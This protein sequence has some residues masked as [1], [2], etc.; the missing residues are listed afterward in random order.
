VR[1]PDGLAVKIPTWMISP[2][3]AQHKLSEQAEL[4]VGAL[5]SLARLLKPGIKA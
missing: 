2:Q 1:H 4:S 5:L 3:A